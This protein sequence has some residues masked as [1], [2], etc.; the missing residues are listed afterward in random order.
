MCR[1]LTKV[2]GFYYKCVVILSAVLIWKFERRE[3][4]LDPW[5]LSLEADPL[6]GWWDPLPISLKD[7]ATPD[8]STQDL[9]TLDFSTMNC[10]TPV[11]GWEVWG[12]KVHGWKVWGW[13][14]W[15]WKVW[16]WKIWGWSLGLKS[17]GLKCPSTFYLPCSSCCQ[18]Y[19]SQLCLCSGTWNEICVHCNCLQ[20][21]DRWTNF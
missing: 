15:G 9:S 7:I 6:F 20:T 5:K 10:P 18:S 12:W 17:P 16:G 2:M 19:I 13:K 8:F 14:V 21:N 11:R 3:I 4:P 1:C